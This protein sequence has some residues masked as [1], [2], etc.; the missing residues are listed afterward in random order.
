MRDF[1]VH[2]KRNRFHRVELQNKTSVSAVIFFYSKASMKRNRNIGKVSYVYIY[3]YTS[4]AHLIP[5]KQPF[6][7]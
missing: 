3:V 6:T 4:S 7:I 5:L 1:K 2:N